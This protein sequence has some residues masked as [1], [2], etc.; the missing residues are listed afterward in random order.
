M[1]KEKFKRILEQLNN[2]SYKKTSIRIE[3]YEDSEESLQNAI[4]D[5]EV[6]LLGEALKKNPHVEKISLILQD[7]GDKGAQALAEV[8]TIKDINIYCGTLGV[9]GGCALAQSN[10]KG[11]TI[12]GCNIFYDENDHRVGEEA[13][14][15]IEALINNKTIEELKLDSTF[16]YKKLLIELIKNTK[17]IHSLYLDG[18][19]FNKEL[20]KDLHISQKEMHIYARDE[21]IILLGDEIQDNNI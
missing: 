9:L 11:L 5:E 13:K 4:G 21:E 1:A 20:F 8:D 12:E 3:S 15:F 18:R 16:I 6:I 10:L 2:G 14:K 7:V 19:S 17:S